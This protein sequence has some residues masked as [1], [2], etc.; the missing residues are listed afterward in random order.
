MTDIAK[1]LFVAAIKTLA[2]QR[3]LVPITR[4]DPATLADFARGALACEAAFNRTKKRLETP[5]EEREDGPLP[6]FDEIPGNGAV[7]V[8]DQGTLGAPTSSKGP[9]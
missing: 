7:V 2:Q 3:G 8:A 4:P 5:L 9:Y 6:G 1:E